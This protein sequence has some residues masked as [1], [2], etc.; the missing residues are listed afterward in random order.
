MKTYY[1]W[2]LLLSLLSACTENKPAQSTSDSIPKTIIKG[3]QPNQAFLKFS[4]SLELFEP[5]KAID[6]PPSE[7]GRIYVDTSSRIA[8][9]DLNRFIR[10]N[11]KKY[12][13]TTD[14]LISFVKKEDLLRIPGYMIGRVK[15]QNEQQVTIILLF[16]QTETLAVT[17]KHFVLSYHSSK[18]GKPLGYDL[19][20][21]TV[22]SPQAIK[23][24]FGRW[25]VRKQGVLINRSVYITQKR[26]YNSQK[27]K[28]IFN[29]GIARKEASR[30][31]EEILYSLQGSPK[32]IN[33]VQ[34]RRHCDS[35]VGYCVDFPYQLFTFS[36]RRALL[37]IDEEFE[38]EDGRAKLVFYR[39]MPSL[40]DHY[41]DKEGRF[42]WQK[43]FTVSKKITEESV[44]KLTYTYLNDDYFVL[45]GIQ[46]DGRIFY[47]K[48]V[49]ETHFSL[50]YPKTQK[51][52]YDKVVE[53]LGK[54]FRVK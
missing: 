2:L 12:Q 15:H 24:Y 20:S 45:S 36:M 27:Y 43:Y 8:E 48:H 23:S 29:K 28:V 7:W 17:H 14:S 22:I 6:Y 26:H 25:G 21:G 53:Q 40:L 37:G 3:D 35:D 42:D 31:K 30:N 5:K 16:L 33:G 32:T 38:S 34:Y 52:V 1:Y 11:F 39:S 13:N 54:S 47:E 46:K 44:K 19:L 9:T 51:A 50:V 18:S 41:L 4:N 10:P 49:G